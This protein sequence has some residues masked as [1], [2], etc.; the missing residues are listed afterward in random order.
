[1]YQRLEPFLYLVTRFYFRN[2]GL[3]EIKDDEGE[4]YK[5]QQEQKKQLDFGEKMELHMKIKRL[6]QQIT[7]KLEKIKELC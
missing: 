6:E 4:I 7:S 1:L 2:S 5:L 3:F